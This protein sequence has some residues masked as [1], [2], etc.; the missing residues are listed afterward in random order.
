MRFANQRQF[1]LPTIGHYLPAGRN[2]SRAA[3]DMA[4]I[5]AIHVVGEGSKPSM[6]YSHAITNDRFEKL[7]GYQ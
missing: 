4:G 1:V 5:R 6:V 2:N 7:A 3:A